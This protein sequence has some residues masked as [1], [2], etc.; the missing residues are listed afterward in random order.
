ML[1]GLLR[2]GGAHAPSPAAL[3]AA[4]S[5][6]LDLPDPLVY[7]FTPLADLTL[8]PAFE[9]AL[10]YDGDRCFVACLLTRPAQ[11]PA[12]TANLGETAPLLYTCPRLLDGVD[13]RPGDVTLWNAWACRAETIAA[14]AAKEAQQGLAAAEAVLIDRSARLLYTGAEADARHFLTSL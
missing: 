3:A 1:Q 4:L 5:K 14:C 12:C 9:A 11:P 10:G 7:R 8:P 13:V 6:E 2:R